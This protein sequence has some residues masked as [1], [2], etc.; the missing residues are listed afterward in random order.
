MVVDTVVRHWESLVAE[1]EGGGRSN[2]DGFAGQTV[3]RKI[4]EQDD[5]R[6][7]SE[8]GHVSLTVKADF[9]Y[10]DDGLVASTYPG[11]LQ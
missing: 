1:Q 5:G 11:W 2:D 4:Q 9:F 8:E 7:Q 3:G 6:H 10:E